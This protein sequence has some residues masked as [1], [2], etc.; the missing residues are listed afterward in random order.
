[1]P[2]MAVAITRAAATCHQRARPSVMR[3]RRWKMSI[4]AAEASTAIT[5]DSATSRASQITP[6]ARRT[7]AMPR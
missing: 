5:T 2:V 4:A 6:G 1:M 3:R 7:A